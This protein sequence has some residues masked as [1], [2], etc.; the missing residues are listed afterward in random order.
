MLYGGESLLDDI[1]DCSCLGLAPRRRQLSCSTAVW[2]TFTLLKLAKT[3]LQIILLFSTLVVSGNLQHVG[4]VAVLC[5]QR[6]IREGIVVR[7]SSLLECLLKVATT[8]HKKTEVLSL[9]FCNAPTLYRAL[10]GSRKNKAFQ[11]PD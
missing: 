6:T 5:R 8:D 7:Q 4:P 9:P 10:W 2:D 1:K 11:Q 3:N